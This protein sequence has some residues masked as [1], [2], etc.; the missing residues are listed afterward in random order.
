MGDT[1]HENKI[2]PSSRKT[3]MEETI[4]G[5]RGGDRTISKVIFKIRE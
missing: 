5:G 4:R 3:W 2:V 1:R